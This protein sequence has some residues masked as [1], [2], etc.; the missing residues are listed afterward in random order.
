MSEL[1]EL[2]QRITELETTQRE[3]Q[4]SEEALQA[5]E[6]RYRRLFE[7]AKDGILIL[8]ADTG[9][10]MDV[11][12]FLVEMLG[13]PHEEFVGKELWEIGPFKN[14]EASRKAFRE[15]QRKEYIRYETLPLESRTGQSIDVEFVSN[16]Y[17]INGDRVIQCNIRDITERVR[18]ERELEIIAT[19][20]AAL[21]NAPTRGDMLPVIV[22]Q[23]L[24]LLRAE[25]AALVMYDP[26]T[27]GSVVV[28]ARGEW[29]DWTGMRL[30]PGHE[31][32]GQALATGR[33]F[34][35]AD[36][37]TD[38]R[39]T[40]PDLFGPLQAVVGMPLIEQGRT[41]GAIWTGRK[42]DMNRNEL[43]LLSVI[44]EISANALYRAEVLETLESR[45]EERTRALA[46]SNERLKELDLLKDEFTSN[47]NHELR[48][49][50]ANIKLYLGLLERG[51]PDKHVIYMQTLD[52]EVARLEKIIEALLDFSRIDR[53][54]TEV[55]LAPINVNQI[56]DWL[57]I[58][59]SALAIE[60]GLT[61]TYA[62]APSLPLALANPVLLTQ[63]VSNFLTNALHYTPPG[64]TVTVTT[65][66]IQDQARDWAIATVRDTGPGILT[67]DRPHL[68]ERFYRGEA[69]RKS[70]A[71]GTGLGLA[72]CKEIVQRLG[73]RITVE[74]E[75]GHGA[76]FS[77][78]LPLA[79]EP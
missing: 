25:G 61:L 20:G 14:I 71:P 59:R 5:S 56:I 57:I 73:G 7:T 75:P 19:V 44:G 21:R 2:R 49:P 15:L 6:T 4:W 18:R 54:F 64:G 51:K 66:L 58:D 40:Q 79:S 10:I 17:R 3:R 34:V 33:L 76:A 72:I 48:T 60:Y 36:A 68:F 8:D 22:D 35:S 46:L 42:T 78:W 9:Q 62:P 77:V 31:V 43:R 39:I 23:V 55:E 41:I 53:D 12:P 74:S 69:A 63:V 50:F 13:Y 16:I 37:Q 67:E 1:A 28:L 24:R 29:T 30:P 27:G 45:V 52:R 11:N 38:S 65:A 26:A 70:K 32:I 47:I